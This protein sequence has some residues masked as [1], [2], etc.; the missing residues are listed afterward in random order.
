MPT[1]KIST[2]V[3]FVLPATILLMA[4]PSLGESTADECKASP[5]SAGP[6]GT[7]WYYRINRTDQRHCWYLGSDATKVRSHELGAMPRAASP[8]SAPQNETA[9][10]SVSTTPAQS[11]PAQTATTQMAPAEP[12]AI[13]TASPGL[14]AGGQTSIDFATRWADLPKSPNLDARELAALSNKYA[15]GHAAVY[16]AEIS[17]ASPIITVDRAGLRQDSAGVGN[18]A[19]V[20]LIGALGIASLLCS[21][22][23]FRIVR[24]PDREAPRRRTLS[25]FAG[26]PGRGSALGAQQSEPAWQLPTLTDPAHDLRTSLH[27]LMC[28]LKRAGAAGNPLHSFVPTGRRMP[29]ESAIQGLSHSDWHHRSRNAA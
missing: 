21:G 12:V 14:P 26:T 13:D 8:G 25:D 6:S 1:P 2:T 19:L 15:Q 17:S 20:S 28:D 29:K 5:G 27:Q 23:V 3:L 7:H 18:F 22:G 24:R 16:A 4:P 11:I 9:A 10:E